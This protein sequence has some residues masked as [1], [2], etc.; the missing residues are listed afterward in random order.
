MLGCRLLG[1]RGEAYLP[2]FARL[3]KELQ[4]RET[5]KSLLALASEVA[6]APLVHRHR[7]MIHP[8]R[9]QDI[10]NIHKISIFVNVPKESVH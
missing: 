2:I 6:S 7:R 8:A 9:L 1:E 5:N 4:S 10:E 3:H